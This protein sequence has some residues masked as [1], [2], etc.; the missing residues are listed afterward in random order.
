MKIFVTG[1]TSFLGAHVVKRLKGPDYDL[2]LLVKDPKAHSWLADLPSIQV[3][4]GSLYN[5]EAWKES[6]KGHDC[7]IHNALLWDNEPTELEMQDVR[8]SALLFEAA[9]KAGIGQIIYTSSAA[10]HRPWSSLMSEEDRIQPETTYGAT[11]AA[12][13]A[14]LSALSHQHGFHYTILRPGAIV[15][16]PAFPGASFRIDRRIR[17]MAEMAAVGQ[18]IRI[19]QGDAR[20]FVGAADLAG[21]Y[22]SLLQQGSSNRVYVTVAPFMTQWEVIARRLVALLRSKS[23]VILDDPPADERRFDVSR[24]KSDLGISLDARHE[25]D[26]AL[27]WLAQSQS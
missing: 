20:Q 14:F 18:E 8:A 12:N 13:E 7:V 17:E 10:V 6:L 22:R 21:V 25:L 3:C 23:E 11:K 4:Q 2:T 15:G 5:I 16:G 27:V 24:L 9:G 1:G 26:Q 19:Q